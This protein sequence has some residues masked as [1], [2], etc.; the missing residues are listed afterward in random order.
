[1]RPN[2]NKVTFCFEDS[3]TRPIPLFVRLQ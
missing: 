2:Q 1:M 3:G